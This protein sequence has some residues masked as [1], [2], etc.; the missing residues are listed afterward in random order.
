MPLADDVDLTHLAAITHGFV[1]ADLEALCREAGMIALRRLL[2]QSDFSQPYI[3]DE[4]LA[5]L[6]VAMADFREALGEVEPSAVREVFVEVPNVAWN[7]VGGLD[8]VKQRLR[9]AVEWPLAHP[10]LFESR[11][12]WRRPR[13]ALALRPA[14]LRQDPPGQGPGHRGRRQFRLRQGAGVAVDV[15]GRIGTRA[16]RRISQSP[17]GGPLHHLLRRDRRL[18]LG[19]LAAAETTPAWPPACSANS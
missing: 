5:T 18:G 4:M 14:R 13:A 8:D 19:A 9:E 12:T 15:R 7:D 6:E 3:P 2:P 10:E 17:A 16:A 1:G 11:R